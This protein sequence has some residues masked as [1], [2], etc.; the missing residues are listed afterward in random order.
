MKDRRATYDDLQALPEHVVG[1]IIDGELY[2]SP[3]PAP[4]HANAKVGVAHAWIIDPLQ[5]TL[6]IFRLENGRG[7]Q[8]SAHSDDEKV[9]AEPFEV[10]ELEISRWWAD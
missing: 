10:L 1:E 9:R 3:R 2:V 6:E 7:T 5:R 4:P 8:I